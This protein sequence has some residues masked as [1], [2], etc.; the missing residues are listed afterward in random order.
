MMGKKVRGGF[1]QPLGGGHR[2]NDIVAEQLLLLIDRLQGWDRG[3]AA[4]A[5]EER[6]VARQS[7]IASNVLLILPI[8]EK[9]EIV[10]YLWSLLTLFPLT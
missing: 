7:E 5:G 6:V 10:K 3:D 4:E 9:K 1:E 2:K 8:L